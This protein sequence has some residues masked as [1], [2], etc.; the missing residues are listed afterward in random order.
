MATRINEDVYYKKTIVLNFWKHHLQF[1]TSQELFSSDDIDLGTRFLLRTIVEADYGRFQKILDLGCG[2]GPL[3]LTL[4]S[5]NDDAVLYMVDRDAL[6]VEYSL[7]NV[8]LNGFSNVQVYGSL[9]Y[10]NITQNDFDLIV[11]NLPGKAGESAITSFLQESVFYLTPQGL[12]AI[13]VVAPLE[14]LVS[15]ILDKTPGVEVVLKRSRPGHIVYHYRFTGQPENQKPA[16]SAIER[17][18]YQRNNSTFHGAGL[19][20]TMQT[21]YGLPEFDTL[22]FGTELVLDAFQC[23]KRPEIRNIVVLNPGQG[24][25]PVVL[26]KILRPQK[27][28]LID[29]DLLALKYST[30]NLNYNGFQ[31]NDVSCYHRCGIG[32]DRVEKTDIVVIMLREEGLAANIMTLQQATG[33]LSDGGMTFISA[34]ST[35]IT[36]LV[37]TIRKGKH[38][39]ILGRERKKGFSCLMLQNA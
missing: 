37:D 19:K 18:I 24:H 35:A 31:V 23:I 14:E 32:P 15:G 4:K 13:V 8:K 26:W 2:Y 3:G 20:Y 11:S 21:A 39:V 12:V 9:G 6:A 7:Q 30:Q 5:L 29:R 10:D 27:I 36:R 33:L 25:L 34:S 38:L 28:T 16:G 22:S 17:G 1:K